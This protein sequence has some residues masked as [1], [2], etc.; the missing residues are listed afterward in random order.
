VKA[1][2]YQGKPG[3]YTSSG[4]RKLGTG[5]VYLDG[6]HTSKYGGYGQPKWAAFAPVVRGKRTK[7]GRFDTRREAE[8]TVKAWFEFKAR[9]EKEK[10]K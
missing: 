3:E 7:L 4:R 6:G 1:R 2:T 5:G 10:V 8:Q 9:F